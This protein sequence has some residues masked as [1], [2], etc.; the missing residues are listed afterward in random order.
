MS[1]AML[2]TVA[3]VAALAVGEIIQA[4]IMMTAAMVAAHIYSGGQR[5]PTQAL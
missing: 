1:G 2:F 3:A 4:L 5:G